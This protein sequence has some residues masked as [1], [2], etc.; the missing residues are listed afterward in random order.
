MNKLLTKNVVFEKENLP[1]GWTSFMFND[2]LI[3]HYGKGLSENQRKTNGSIPVYGS[4]GIIGYCNKA[5]TNESCLI[6][7]RKGSAGKVYF[8]NESCWPIDT[9]YF[10]PTNSI[11]NL[12]FLYYFFKNIKNKLIDS[13]TAIPSL[14]RNDIYSLHLIL[15]PLNEQKRIVQKI[16]SIF[17]Q[18]DASRISLD[19]IKVLLKQNKQFVLKQA[20]E[21]IHGS[22]TTELGNLI[23]FSK[24]GFTGRPNKNNKGNPRL[25]IETITNSN[26]IFINDDKSKFIDIPKSKEKNYETQKGDLFFCRQNGNKNNVGKC[27]V[28]KNII[29]SMIFSDSL[30]QFRLNEK[31]TPEYVAYFT[32]TTSSRNQIE[33]Y[34]STTAGNFSIN[35]TNLKKFMITFPVVSQ[36][37][38]IVT[39][40][41]SIFGRIDAIENS[42]I[43]TAHIILRIKLAILL[44]LFTMILYHEFYNTEK[45]I[46]RYHNSR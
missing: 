18:I 10:L 31:I 40:I 30:I 41:E 24:N 39:K 11:F 16:E 38:Q 43:L 28:L 8:V 32:I 37:K 46:H 22:E 27:K 9:V 14:R 1:K 29:K 23:L 6:I 2:Y 20:F 25:G 21:K 34:C 26:S 45:N 35:G 4:S 19:R 3:V 42:I 7:G 17:T 44:I 12:K 33:Q 13:S 36:Q 5:L 15:P